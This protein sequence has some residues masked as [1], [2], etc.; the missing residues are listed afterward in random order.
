MKDGTG[1]HRARK[2]R[3]RTAEKAQRNLLRAAPAALDTAGPPR[4]SAHLDVVQPLQGFVFMTGVQDDREI[5]ALQQLR[6]PASVLENTGIAAGFEQVNLRPQDRILP[7]VMRTHEAARP[8]VD[9][10]CSEL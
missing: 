10:C 2:V 9:G 4:A 8:H 6:E 1:R 7:S 5:T 3:H